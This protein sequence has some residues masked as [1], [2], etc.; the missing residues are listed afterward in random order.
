MIS[1]HLNL[2]P[3]TPQ[4][5]NALANII[6]S[7]MPMDP[8]WDYRFVNRKKFPQ[9]NFASSRNMFKSMLKEEGVAINVVTFSTPCETEVE[10]TPQALAVWEIEYNPDQ[11][12]KP[13]RTSISNSSPWL[14]LLNFSQMMI[15]AV[16]QILSVCRHL[17]KPFSRPKSRSLII[18]SMEL[19]FTYASLQ[20][21]Q[22]INDEEPVQCCV[23]G[24]WNWRLLV[25]SLSHYSAAPWDSSS[26]QHL[27]LTTLDM[28][29]CRSKARK[30]VWT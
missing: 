6:Y 20:L 14:Q 24:E 28:L 30:K 17:M 1:Q 8:Q 3:A 19:S 4:D 22:T 29:L 5:I 2:R 9:D 21:I 10:W 23:G 12:Y 27:D 18:V 26:T 16:M 25:E 13:P 7:A 15:L 11:D